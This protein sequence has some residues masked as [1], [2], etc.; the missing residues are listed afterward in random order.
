[1]STGKIPSG[2]VGKKFQRKTLLAEATFGQLVNQLAKGVPLDVPNEHMEK[3]ISV[4]QAC[5]NTAS[6]EILEVKVG[7]FLPSAI[8]LT[9]EGAA[10]RSKREA[11]ATR[12]AQIN[13]VLKGLPGFPGTVKACRS[14]G[15]KLKG[16]LFNLEFEL[17]SES[18]RACIFRTDA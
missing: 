7:K 5:L 6:S 15:Y 11:K 2:G 17:S 1:M 16:D 3:L 8:G 18:V 9:P 14:A 12:L 10:R 4:L 13:S